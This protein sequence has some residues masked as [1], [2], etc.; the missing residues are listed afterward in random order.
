MT[1]GSVTLERYRSVRIVTSLGQGDR[2]SFKAP[3]LFGARKSALLEKCPPRR[4]PS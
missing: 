1:S 2:L 4:L 3:I